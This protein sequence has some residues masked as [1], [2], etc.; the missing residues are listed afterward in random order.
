MDDVTKRLIGEKMLSFGRRIR[1]TTKDNASD[2]VRE[3]I[4]DDPRIIYYLRGCKITGI[5]QDYEIKAEYDN[6]DTPPS[7]I[8]TVLSADECVDI[9]CR[10]VG[11]YKQKLIAVADKNAG[12]EKAV[13]R[14][15]E[16]YAAFYPNLTAIGLCAYSIKSEYT[17]FEFTFGYRIGKV[18]HDMMEKEVTDEVKRIAKMLFTP[19]MPDEAKI[20]LAHNYLCSTVRYVN[21]DKTRLDT[22]YTQSAYGA[23]IKKECVCQGYAEAFKR[24][25]DEAGIGCGVICGRCEGG[26]AAHAWNTVSLGMTGASYHIDAT[27]D[28]SEGRPGY[29]Y[30]C[31]TDTFL[32]GKRTWNRRYT[33]PCRGG[34]DVLKKARDYVRRNKTVLRS[35]GIGERVL[36]CAGASV[37]G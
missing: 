17:V 1:F 5:G 18:K 26:G 23:L 35:R 31:R 21:N 19:T 15:N 14:F 22:S 10:Y 30:F 13:D 33:K 8:Q 20:Y 3:A 9:M 25:M 16:K 34:D 7:E 6:K 36:D 32:E 12:L 37:W 29:E 2:L 24:L 27:W 11:G 4:R 28:S